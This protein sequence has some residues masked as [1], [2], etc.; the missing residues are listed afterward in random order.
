MTT[1]KKAVR[2]ML[3]GEGKLMI[4]QAMF[5][6][7]NRLKEGH[8]RQAIHEM[9][10]REN[11]SITADFT[12]KLYKPAV[13]PFMTCGSESHADTARTKQMTGSAE[14]NISSGK[15]INII[16]KTRTG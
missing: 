11:E 15:R 4:E 6:Q 2:R 16:G 3:Q 1:T 8:D 5:I 10:Q 13:R 7:Q 9:L 12:S 14:T